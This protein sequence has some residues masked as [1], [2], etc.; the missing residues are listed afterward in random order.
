VGDQI[1]YKNE[2]EA[3]TVK[4]GSQEYTIVFKKNIIAIVK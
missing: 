4:D 2:Y 3:T 1:I